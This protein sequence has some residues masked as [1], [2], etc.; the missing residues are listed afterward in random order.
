M[1]EQDKQLRLGH[2]VGPQGPEGSDGAVGPQGPEGET[3][4]Q[5]P[6]GD[7][8]PQ[9]PKGDPGPQGPAG[10][11]GASPYDVAV[12]QGYTGNEAQFYAALVS[13]QRAPFLPLAGGAL[14]GS[15]NLN[16]HTLLLTANSAAAILPQGQAV[17]VMSEGG[18]GVV[19]HDGQI[20]ELEDPAEEDQAASKHY[21]DA[22]VATCLSLSGGTMEGE[23]RMNKNHLYGLLPPENDDEPATKGYADS[24]ISN[25]VPAG[26]IVL[27]SGS[28]DTIPTGWTL[29]NGQNGAPDLRDRF[30]VGAGASYA[31][32]ETGGAAGV[33]LSVAQLPAHGHGAG[34]LSAQEAGTH[35]HSYTY[36]SVT[37]NG[38]DFSGSGNRIAGDVSSE[39]A[40]TQSAGAHTHTVGGTTGV[41]G[42]GA[43]H[44]N[45]PPYYAL[46]YIMKLAISVLQE[47][48]A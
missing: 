10:E 18:G 48:E 47:A 15:L 19:I 40:T 38:T 13:L 11:D 9:G 25:G 36:D 6:K 41:T 1:S 12:E 3:G 46:C 20:S 44:E 24:I 8:G 42:S 33:A 4:P 14:T 39:S 45:R 21:V 34:T 16:G 29:C 32:D 7:P 5:G 37:E 23:L 2:V 28:E 31:V 17:R 43:E 22:Q 27:W 26:V 30:V 35:T